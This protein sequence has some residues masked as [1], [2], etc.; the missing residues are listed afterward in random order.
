MQFKSDG[1]NKIMKTACRCPK[2]IL[3]KCLSLKLYSENT[4]GTV[5]IRVVRTR[6]IDTSF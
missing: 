4:N 6:M 1:I 2:L 5:A 3:F